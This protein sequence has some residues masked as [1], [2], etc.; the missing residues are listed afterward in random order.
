MVVDSTP[1]RSSKSH[2]N[3]L[4]IIQN[5]SL[6]S[7]KPLGSRGENK[8]QPASRNKHPVETTYSSEKFPTRPRLQCF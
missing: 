4:P 8:G 7:C 1:T 6:A 5:T 3:Q 2:C